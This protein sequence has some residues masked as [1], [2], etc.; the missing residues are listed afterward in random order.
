MKA[1][2][3]KNLFKVKE[4]YVITTDDKV[5]IGDYGISFAHGI[6]LSGRGWGLFKNDGTPKGK[7]NAICE[8]TK[9]VIY[10]SFEL[11]NIPIFDINQYIDP[12]KV[13]NILSVTTIYELEQ[14][15]SFPYHSQYENLGYQTYNG[16]VIEDN[17][18]LSLK[19]DDGIKFMTQG[20]YWFGSILDQKITILEHSDNYQFTLNELNELFRKFKKSYRSG[21]F[22]QEKSFK[23]G[24]IEFIDHIKSTKDIQ[25]IEL[26]QIDNQ[27]IVKNVK[28]GK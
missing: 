26:E 12:W 17:H 3:N 1:I 11:E 13:G 4:G 24:F 7:L 9:K 18:G 2:I 21:K 10:S 5:E 14:P 22:K 25:E 20:T 8:N 27:L 6:N 28:N 15:K 19:L 23:D 16:K